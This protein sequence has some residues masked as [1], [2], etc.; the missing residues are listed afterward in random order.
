MIYIGIDPGANGGIGIID[1]KEGTAQVMPY[2]DG[3]LRTILTECN[4]AKKIMVER[5]HAMP[6][7]G[8]KSSFN[9]GETFGYILGMLDAFYVP[10][11]LVLPQKWKKE[12]GCTADKQTSIDTCRRLF[13]T[14]ELKRTPKCR[15]D[16][17]GMA[18][19]LLIAEYARRRMK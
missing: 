15:T 6:G 13:P 16:H 1:T 5:V 12:F 19:A 18:E 17:D 14:V 8:T 9:F 4:G 11:E 3:G 7:E 2:T 10:Y